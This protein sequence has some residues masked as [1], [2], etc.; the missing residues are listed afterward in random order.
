[1]HDSQ[2]KVVGERFVF[3]ALGTMIANRLFRTVAFRNV[4]Q[5]MAC[6]NF[7]LC[8]NIR[9]EEIWSRALWSHTPRVLR[10]SAAEACFPP[11]PQNPKIQLQ[12]AEA[13][14]PQRGAIRSRGQHVL[15]HPHPSSQARKQP[16]S[17]RLSSWKTEALLRGG[18]LA[19][20]VGDTRG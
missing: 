9:K 7:T 18:G 14:C 19:V 8:A 16:R 2:V 1:M 12:R 10:R 4:P 13:P 3:H 6:V 11:H 5:T 15:S 20:V 17:P